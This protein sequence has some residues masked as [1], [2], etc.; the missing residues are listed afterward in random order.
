MEL[1]LSKT[2][3]IFLKVKNKIISH[4]GILFFKKF[5]KIFVCEHLFDA[6]HTPECEPEPVLSVVEGT[7]E[8]GTKNYK[9]LDFFEN[10]V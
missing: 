3:I 5:I 1:C 8:R 4:F 10:Y 6:S 9:K 7:H 2:K